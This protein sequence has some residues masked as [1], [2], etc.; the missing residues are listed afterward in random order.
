M[1]SYEANYLLLKA[2]NKKAW[3][4]EFFDIEKNISLK[5]SKSPDFYESDICY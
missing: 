1:R 2:F 3:R 4:V 5:E